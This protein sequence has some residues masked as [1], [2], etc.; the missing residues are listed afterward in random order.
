MIPHWA[1]RVKV[2]ANYIMVVARLRLRAHTLPKGSTNSYALSGGT[3]ITHND[4]TDG[5]SVAR[6]QIPHVSNRTD[7]HLSRS[8]IPL[9][10]TIARNEHKERAKGA[11]KVLGAAGIF[12]RIQ[13]SGECGP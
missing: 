13:S 9:G 8:H 10:S 11:E 7:K 4:T 2:F 6:G 3:S 1:F 12:G 5:I